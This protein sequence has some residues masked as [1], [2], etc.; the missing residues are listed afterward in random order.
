MFKALWGCRLPSGYKGILGE[1]WY[2]DVG[3]TK[4]IKL[5]KFGGMHL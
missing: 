5:L 2:E 3:W 4:V 1:G